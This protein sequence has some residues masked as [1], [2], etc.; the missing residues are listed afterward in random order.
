[1]I[2]G[3][4]PLTTSAI[5]VIPT[6]ITG[7]GV[8]TR[9]FR[10]GTSPYWTM[11]SPIQLVTRNRRRVGV[12]DIVEHR[13]DAARAASPRAGRAGVRRARAEDAGDRAIVATT[14]IAV[15]IDATSTGAGASS[16]REVPARRIRALGDGLGRRGRAPSPSPRSRCPPSI[17]SAGYEFSAAGD[18]VAE[19][20]AADQRRRSRPSRARTGSSG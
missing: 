16:S 3:R 7:H 12:L 19:A 1:M 9:K 2:A 18:H 8:S 14:A 10:N 15:P 20:L 13:L 4:R 6:S 5:S 11:W 17:A